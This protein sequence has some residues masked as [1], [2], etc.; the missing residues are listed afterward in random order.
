MGRRVS[1]VACI[2]AGYV[3]GPTCAVIANKNKDVSVTVVDLNQDR[4]DAWNSSQL[5]IF[6]PRLQEIVELP[7]DGEDG[8]PPNLFF[9]TDIDAAIKAADLIFISVNTPTKL[10]GHGAGRASDLAYVESAARRIAEVAT[11]DKIIVEKSTVPAGTAEDLR[12]IFS[13]LATPG[14]RFDILSNPE[15]LAEGTAIN[16]LLNPDRILI[17]SLKSASTLR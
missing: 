11:S 5:P 10:V 14:V 15:F 13:S 7:R 1:N 6:E 2:G 16:D 8:R 12:D 9:S 4:I 17:G 3:G